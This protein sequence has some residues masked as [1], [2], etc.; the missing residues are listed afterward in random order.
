MRW[1]CLFVVLVVV[2]VEDVVWEDFCYKELYRG[3]DV[4]MDGLIN[5][6]SGN[7]KG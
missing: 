2:V 7:L 3:M 5:F 6:W 1:V 4:W